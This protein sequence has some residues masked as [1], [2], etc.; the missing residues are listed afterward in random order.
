M[1]LKAMFGKKL[2][3]IRVGMGLTQEKFAELVNLEPNTITQMENGYKGA[4]FTTIEKISKSLNVKYSDLFNFEEQ[5]KEKTIIPKA[6]DNEIRKL[7]KSA[8]KYL[9]KM[10][11][12]FIEFYK[13]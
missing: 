7:D 5:I 8:Q 12:D 11:V 9:L 10:V 4:S 1:T 6:I 3:N 13:K 2:K